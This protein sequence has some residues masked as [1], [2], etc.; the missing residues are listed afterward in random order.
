MQVA[1]LAAP[2]ALVEIEVIA[3]KSSGKPAQ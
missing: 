2:W 1:A 3:V